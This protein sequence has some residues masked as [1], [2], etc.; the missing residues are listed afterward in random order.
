MV[1]NQTVEMLWQEG[2]IHAIN[3]GKSTIMTR[4]LSEK[5]TKIKY[6]LILIRTVKYVK[7]LQILLYYMLEYIYIG[8]MNS[9]K[10]G[11]FLREFLA[12]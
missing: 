2:Y 4:I 1:P 9:Q 6:G 10:A 11:N 12:L 7:T 8:R 3:I 5:K